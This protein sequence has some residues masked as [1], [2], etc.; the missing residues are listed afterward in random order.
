VAI[1]LRYPDPPLSGELAQL[2]PWSEDDVAALVAVGEDPL[3]RRYRGS[4]PGDLAATRHALADGESERARGEGLE[5]AVCVAGTDV[6]VG[7]L[8]LWRVHPRHRTAA[9][10]WALLPQARG[11]GVATGA[12]RLAG[13]WALHTLGLARL[14]AEI[15]AG[16]AA[17]RR[18][19]ERCGFVAE[20]TL[21]ARSQIP[22]GGRADVVLY[23][24]LR[25]ELRE[26]A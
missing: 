19:A 1:E 2:R 11:H 7:S 6:P 26:R 24:L 5:L 13:A 25:D 8:S 12:V 15:E 23:G 20:G 14:E 10:S 22:G 3:V 4:L 17:S 16:N 18:V 9:L 21:R